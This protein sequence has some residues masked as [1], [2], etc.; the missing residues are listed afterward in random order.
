MQL[1]GM[2]SLIKVLEHT[3]LSEPLLNLIIGVVPAAVHVQ[4]QNLIF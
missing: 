4:Q 3:C 1:A 2:Q